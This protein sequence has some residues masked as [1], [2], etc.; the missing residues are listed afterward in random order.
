MGKQVTIDHA[1]SF[2]GKLLSDDEGWRKHKGECA[3]GVQ[4]VFYKFGKPLGITAN[5]RRGKKVRGKNIPAGTA[6]ASFRG[7]SNRYQNDHA[8]ILIKETAKG[9][10]VYD[11][12]NHPQKKWG[13]RLLPFREDEDY[14]NNGNLFYVIELDSK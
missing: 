2:V 3:S 6:I 5:W 1:K 12:Y 7:D 14:S 9:L 4:Y 11:Q 13:P 8:A 10:E